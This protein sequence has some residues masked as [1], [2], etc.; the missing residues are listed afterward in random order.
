MA[1]RAA[2]VSHLALVLGTRS[3][4]LCAPAAAAVGSQRTAAAHCSSDWDSPL[5]THGDNTHVPPDSPPPAAPEN[6]R[7]VH[8]RW[9]GIFHAYRDPCPCFPRQQRIPPADSDRAPTKPPR[10]WGRA[11]GLP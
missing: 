2:P 11:G 1:T 9:P 8:W 10:P 7:P 4:S 5:T 3:Y 6:G